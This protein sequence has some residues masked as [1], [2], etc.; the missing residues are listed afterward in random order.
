MG[1]RTHEEHPR[2]SLRLSFFCERGGES[3]KREKR[4]SSQACVAERLYRRSPVIVRSTVRG[5][6]SAI[7][8]HPSCSLDIRAS[9]TNQQS[10]I[11]RRFDC[12]ID[13][14]RLSSI[15]LGWIPTFSNVFDSN[16]VEWVLGW[17]RSLSVVF[18]SNG[19]E[20]KQFDSTRSDLTRFNWALEWAEGGGRVRDM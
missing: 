20:W 12:V 5:H 11:N 3:V 15:G 10:R 9:T 6:P 17:I 1:C 7:I 14:I 8:N 13:R 4:R 18:D 2:Q 19:F 16:G